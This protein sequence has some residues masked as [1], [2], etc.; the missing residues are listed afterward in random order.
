MAPII[1]RPIIGQCV[2]GASLVSDKTMLIGCQFQTLTVLEVNGL[3]QLHEIVLRKLHVK[4]FGGPLWVTF[5]KQNV[6]CTHPF[7]FN[8]H[9]PGEPV[10]DG[11]L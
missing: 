2:I 5:L 8:G 9:F 1:G 7:H 4:P 3:V 10:L 6:I 11:S